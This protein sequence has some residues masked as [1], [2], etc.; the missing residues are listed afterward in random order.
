METNRIQSIVIVGGGTAGWM[1]AA[2][3]ARILGPD[4]AGITLVE[5]DEIGTVGVGEATIPQ[6]NIFNRMLGI[7]ED[8]FVR[9]TKGSFKLGIEFVDWGG[10]GQRYFHPFGNIGVDMGGVSFH[11]FWQRLRGEPEF[12]DVEDYSVM[13]KAA[14]HGKFMRP[15]TAP[16]SLLS[17]IAYAFHFDAGLYALYLRELAEASGVRRVEGKI[18][19]VARHG[20]AGHIQHVT[21]ADGRTVGGQLFID[22]SGFGGLLIGRALGVPEVVITLASRGAMVVGRTTVAEVAAH[23]VDGAVDPTGAGDSFA[24]L[25]LDAR[26]R[27]AEPAD[28][29][30]SA[31]RIVAE[32]I[33]QP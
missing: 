2:A 14:R 29:A 13:A 16:G 23:A 28:A 3:L 21:M 18:I 5:S 30:D 20:E 15:T 24:L 22:C 8:D 19:D 4:Y 11:A 26:S 10:I 6:I 9:R 1:T 17:S 7:D 12:A 31:A 32:L 25:Y 33:A 27:G